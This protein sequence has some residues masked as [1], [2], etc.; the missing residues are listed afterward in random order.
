MSTSFGSNADLI[1]HVGSLYIHDGDLIAD[2]TYGKGVFWKKV[3]KK[4]F[5]LLASDLHLSRPAPAQD[6]LFDG[7]HEHFLTADLRSLPYANGSLDIVVLDPPYI[8]NPGAH[9]ADHRYNNAQTTKGLYHKDILNTLYGPGMHE[10][11]RV[12]KSG[13]QLWVKCKD[14]I[15]SGE[16]RWSHREIY[17]LA[18]GVGYFSPLDQAILHAAATTSSNRWQRQLHLRKNHSVL[19]IFQRTEKSVRCRHGGDRRSA[20]FQVGKNTNLK[21]LSGTNREYKLD[22]LARDHPGIF[23]SLQEGKFRSVHAAWKA[24]GLRKGEPR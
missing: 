9:I 18:V 3:D 12:L 24:A 7:S 4:R 13:G 20:A 19:W 21:S 23:A 10:A 22:R 2:V 16:Q 1:A 15:E 14:E 17:N 6:D 5:T 11:A 8:H